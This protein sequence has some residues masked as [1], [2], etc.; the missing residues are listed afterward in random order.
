MSLLA[1]KK[2]YHLSK[3]RCLIL[4]SVVL[5]KAN[6]SRNLIFEHWIWSEI[7]TVTAI[8][9]QIWK[10]HN[11]YSIFLPISLIC[12]SE[13]ISQTGNILLTQNA[14]GGKGPQ[15]VTQPCSGGIS[16]PS[17]SAHS[18]LSSC[19]A[20]PGRVCSI[21]WPL[22]QTLADIEEIPFSHNQG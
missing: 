1:E 5:L 2:S 3:K 18:F 16:C 10:Y 22:L 17:L 9:L 20:S 13:K 14:S 21:L 4:H 19:L 15:G 7:I 6:F 11:R 12:K 8:Q